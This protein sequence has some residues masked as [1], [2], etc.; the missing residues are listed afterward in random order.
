M[1]LDYFNASSSV[2]D[3]SYTALWPNAFVSRQAT[4]AGR[5]SRWIRDTEL[6]EITKRTPSI[7]RPAAIGAS[8][9]SVKA[10]TFTVTKVYADG[11]SKTSSWLS[12]VDDTTTNCSPN[13][14]KN[15]EPNQGKALVAYLISLK[16]NYALPEAP[17]PAE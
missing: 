11:T 14:I 13:T 4:A 3:W 2:T 1:M 16:R 12:S 6:S 17:E 9:P 8:V 7:A 10:H 5:I 15:L